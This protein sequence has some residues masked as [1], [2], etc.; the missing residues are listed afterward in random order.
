[1]KNHDIESGTANWKSSNWSGAAQTVGLETTNVYLGNNALRVTKTTPAGTGGY[2]QDNTGVAAGSWCTLSAYVKVSG[3][4]PSVEG[5]GAGVYASFWKYTESGGLVRAGSDVLGQRIT[6]NTSADGWDRVTVTFQVPAGTD[7]VSVY[8]GITDA[9]G[10]AYF[11]CFQLENAMVA[12]DYNL[13]TNPQ[14]DSSAS[15]T[16]TTGAGWASSGRAEITGDPGGNRNIVQTVP[17]NK[18]GVNFRVSGKAGGISGGSVPITASSRYFALDLGIYF[19]DGTTEWKV[20]PFNPDSTG[21]QFVSQAVGPTEA[22]RN[23]KIRSVSFY[24]IYYKNANKVWFDDFCLNIDAT[25]TAYAYDDKTGNLLSASDNAQNKKIYDYDESSNEL[26][27]VTDEALSESYSYTYDTSNKHRLVA[28]RSN[29]TGL[30]FRFGYDGA[31]GNVTQT[32]MGTVTTSGTLNTSNPYLKTSQEYDALGHYVTKTYDQRGKVT[33]FDVDGMS[34]LVNSVTDPKGNVT[35]YTYDSADRLTGVSSG[36]ASNTYGYDSRSRLSAITHNGFQYFFTYDALGNQKAV[37][38]VNGSGSRQLISN[39]YWPNSGQ[40]KLAA[41]GNG[42]TRHYSYNKYGQLWLMMEAEDSSNYILWNEY[43]ADGTL[44]VTHDKA[45]GG[46]HYYQYDLAG[47]LEARRTIPYSGSVSSVRYQYDNQNRLTGE[48]YI[49]DG[50]TYQN[51]YSYGPDSRK[52]T[53]NLFNGT[54]VTRVY[55]SLGREYWT[56]VELGSAMVRRKLTFVGVSGQ[57]TT[58]LVNRYV[59]Q[60]RLNGTAQKERYWD[61]TYDDNGNIAAITDQY[62][63]KITY[64]Y[65]GLNQLVW[66]NNQITGKMTTYSY[67]AG[68]NMVGQQEYPYSVSGNLEAGMTGFATFSY[69]DSVWKDLLT[70]YKGQSITYDQI[71]NP[72]AYRDG[73]T[74]TWDCRQLKTLNKTGLSMAFQYDAD[75]RRVKKTVNGTA[76]TYW[77]DTDGKIMKMQKGND[78]L[79]FM[80]EGDGSLIGF[81]LNGTPYY[82]LYNGQGDV[83]GLMD[84]GANLAVEYVYDSWGRP[85]SVTGTLAA[86]V[87]QLNPFR[88]RGYEYDAETGLYYLLSRYY[89]PMTMRFVNADGILG[90]NQDM[91]AYNLFIYC[92][93]NP[94]NYVDP[95]GYFNL[96]NSVKNFFKSF[97]NDYQSPE[98][99]NAVDAVSGAAPAVAGTLYDLGK[100]YTARIE[101]GH[102][103]QDQR[104]VH[105]IKKGKEVANQNDNGTPHHANKNK[106][107]EPPASIKK[108]LK[109][110]TGWDWDAKNQSHNAISFDEAAKQYEYFYYSPGA[111]PA[112]Y[113]GY[114]WSPS[115]NFSPFG[116]QVPVFG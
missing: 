27:G 87:G 64:R 22:N 15:W 13:L 97:I 1:M 72:L 46:S 90:V 99:V 82:Y 106:K 31:S 103:P 88:Y 91:V 110:Q 42:D 21:A 113:H 44:A 24:A 12:G 5:G 6:E 32:W 19:A 85:V 16:Y 55:D 56:D 66:E 41:Y 78:I 77:R 8:G 63:R 105:I 59:T 108:E 109:K 14:F 96:W 20:V 79:L 92:S 83:I 23:K 84:S 101:P 50:Q 75:G 40:L 49:F 25:G 61:Y 86:T 39:T 57:R 34:G 76:T 114:S 7:R 33:T 60:T 51:T 98:S 93:N 48:S 10:T 112:P 81:T 65:D 94:I 69:G 26:V 36:N 104:H 3:I 29:Q 70:A 116:P 53:S 73:M 100:G 11:D 35:S 9:T 38:L 68:G 89:D 74:M 58:T 107:G 102:V 43:D 28:A 54:R 47:R 2:C 62:G 17:I 111:N 45:F 18:T 4:T 52:S 37:R 115:F 95:T 71:G 80:Y 67:D 30:G